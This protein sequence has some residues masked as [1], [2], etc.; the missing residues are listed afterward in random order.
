MILHCTYVWPAFWKM[1]GWMDGPSGETGE[2]IVP[3]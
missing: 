2:F 3:T 1:D